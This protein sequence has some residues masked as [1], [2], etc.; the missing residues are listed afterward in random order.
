VITVAIRNNSFQQKNDSAHI[1][2]NGNNNLKHSSVY[3]GFCDKDIP[4]LRQSAAQYK[5]D[6]ITAPISGAGLPNEWRRFC[7][8][9]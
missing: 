7:F 3:L 1:Q 9:Q 5:K 2:R 8:L 4:S 6:G